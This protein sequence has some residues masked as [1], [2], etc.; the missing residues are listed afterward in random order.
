MTMIDKSLP[1]ITVEQAAKKLCESTKRINDALP[2]AV[3][4]LKNLSA[5]MERLNKVRE[6]QNDR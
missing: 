5:A 2:T 3:E 1:G 4:A 6:H